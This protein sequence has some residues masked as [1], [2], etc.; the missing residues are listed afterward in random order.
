M[1]N[2]IH[3]LAQ[4]L[5]GKATIEECGLDELQ[6]ITQR[7]PYFAPAQFLLIFSF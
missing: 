1:G 5:T 2:R 6:I 3:T 7:Y 4:Q